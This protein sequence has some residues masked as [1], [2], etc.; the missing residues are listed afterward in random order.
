MAIMSKIPIL[1][2]LLLAGCAGLGGPPPAPG[3]S[4]EAVRA[5]MG[6]PSAVHALPS[7]IQYEYGGGAF[8]Q[9]AWM[10]RFDPAGKLV[11]LEQVRS[12]EKFATIRPGVATRADVLAALGQPSET[13]RVFQHNY[14]VWSYRYKESGVWN[15]MMHVHFDE[16]GVVRMM[17][18]GPDTLYERRPFLD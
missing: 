16:G 15:S 2:A 9:Y 17:Q 10:A 12:G 4:M 1:F 5:R 13:S 11:S 8:G 18:S 6:E 14:E 7:G 3:D